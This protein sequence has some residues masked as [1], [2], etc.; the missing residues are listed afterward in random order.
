MHATVEDVIQQV[1]SWPKEAR[2]E[3]VRS[4]NA[5]T[6]LERMEEIARK[7]HRRAKQSPLTDD[8]I[9]DVVR[10][11]RRDRPLHQR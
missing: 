4:L 8:V 5:L 10:E 9:D 2:L 3:L 6:A 1:K 11:V 7:V